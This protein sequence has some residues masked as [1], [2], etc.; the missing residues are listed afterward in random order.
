MAGAVRFQAIKR[1]QNTNQETRKEKDRFRVSKLEQPFEPMWSV[2]VVVITEFPGG[3]KFLRVW[4]QSRLDRVDERSAKDATEVPVEWYSWAMSIIIINI[5]TDL[6]PH[7]VGILV[8]N[9]GCCH[10][11]S[12]LSQQLAPRLVV[13]VK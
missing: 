10:V 7:K 12:A 13:V 5:A 2:V 11:L 3:S 9:A 8:F 1:H 6:E 4:I